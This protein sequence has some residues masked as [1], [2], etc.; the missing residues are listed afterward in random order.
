LFSN[1]AT[2]P[3]NRHK[4][5]KKPT[6]TRQKTHGVIASPSLK[7][8]TAMPVPEFEGAEKSE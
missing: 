7:E 5:D 6:K 4:T 8:A 3:T 2:P 1:I